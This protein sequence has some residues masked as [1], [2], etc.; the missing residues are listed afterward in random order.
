VQAVEAEMKAYAKG[1]K[2]IALRRIE[3]KAVLFDERFAP[4]VKQE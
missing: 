2:G 1:T 4:A 3:G